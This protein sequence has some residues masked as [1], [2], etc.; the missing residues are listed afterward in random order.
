M[1]IGIGKFGPYVRFDGKFTSLE[2]TD[3]PYTIALPRAMALVEQKKAKDAAAKIPLATFPEEPEMQVL[4][5]RYGPYISYKGKNYPI[6]R[7]AYPAALTLDEARKI[8]EA[9][10]AKAKK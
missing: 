7:K 9:K 8:I 2:K 1:V 5:G 4:N 3:D 10:E 6:P